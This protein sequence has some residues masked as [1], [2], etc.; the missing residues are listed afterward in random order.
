MHPF[1]VSPDFEQGHWKG[2]APRLQLPA[3]ADFV[4]FLD[5]RSGSEERLQAIFGNLMFGGVSEQNDSGFVVLGLPGS[6]KSIGGCQGANIFA[7]QQACRRGVFAFCG[8][9][10]RGQSKGR[11]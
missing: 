3:P 1:V 4:S 9:R 8:Q 10:T 7:I 11:R 5:R 2:E 6:Q